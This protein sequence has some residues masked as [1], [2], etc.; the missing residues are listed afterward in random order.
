VVI[1]LIQVAGALGL[2]EKGGATDPD[3]GLTDA[4][5]DARHSQLRAAYQARLADWVAGLNPAALDF[6]NAHH[7][8]MLG[9]YLPGRADL[10]A[11]IRDATAVVVGKVA[12]VTPRTSGALVELDVVQSLKGDSPTRLYVLQASALRPTADWKGF[13]IADAASDPLL[14]PGQDVVLLLSRSGAEPNAFE[15]Q[16]GSGLYYLRD[17]AV[18]SLPVNP[19]RAAVDG[20]PASAFVASVLAISTSQP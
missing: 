15:I 3:A 17:G 6:V 18:F 11:A 10:P 7:A 14:L 1:G 8:D 19:F 13:V 16:S 5:K 12:A 9:S 2:P 4:Q 20:Q